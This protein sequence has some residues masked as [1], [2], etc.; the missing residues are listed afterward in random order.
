MFQ[1]KNKEKGIGLVLEGGGARGAYQIGVMKALYENNIHFSAIVGTSIGAINGAYLAQH[2]FDTIYQM[3]SSMS[4]QDLFGLDD[5]EMTKLVHKNVDFHLVK[6]LSKKL[7]EALKNGGLD[8][9]KMRKI[10]SESI[11]EEKIRQSE[12][13]FGLVTMCISD[14][15]PKEL[16]IED[17]EKGKLIDYILATSNLPVFKRAI[18][19]QKKYLDGGVWDNCPVQMLERKGYQDAIVI[20]AYKRNRIR[21]YHGIIKRNHITM[22]MIEPVESLGGILNFDTTNLNYLLKYGYYDGLKFVKGLEGRKYYLM[23]MAGNEVT[24]KLENIDYVEM[25]NLASLLK[26]KLSPYKTMIEETK[27]KIIP[28]LLAKAKIGKTISLKESILLLLE[29]I[30]ENEK[31]ERFQIYTLDEFIQKLKGKTMYKNSGNEAIY[32]FIDAI[33]T[34]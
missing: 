23:K 12:I 22:H 19:D 27:T 26:I 6:Y 34:L 25:A 28:A 31:I 1:I 9:Q 18:V 30:A 5:K 17:M 3:W 33:E 8:T 13:A 11:E 7:N 10:M 2:S 32:Q 29:Y 21:G 14:M 24:R 4:F 15:S 16:F 20:R